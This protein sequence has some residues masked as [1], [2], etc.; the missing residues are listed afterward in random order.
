MFTEKPVVSGAETEYSASQEKFW[1]GPYPAEQ[2]PLADKEIQKMAEQLKGEGHQFE[3]TEDGNEYALR[4]KGFEG[5]THI[6]KVDD[7][8]HVDVK[9]IIYTRITQPERE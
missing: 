6:T 1:E 2:A 7:P 3:L 5:I 9:G 8:A 4:V